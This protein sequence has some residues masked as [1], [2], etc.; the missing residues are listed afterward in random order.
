[1]KTVDLTLRQIIELCNKNNKQCHKCPLFTSRLDCHKFNTEY[2]D[3][4]SGYNVDQLMEEE[5]E[6]E[7]NVQ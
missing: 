1:M 2:K 4:V 3:V 7:Y 6:V 5:V